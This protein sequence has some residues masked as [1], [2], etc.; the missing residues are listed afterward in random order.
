ML[1]ATSARELEYRDFRP[2]IKTG[3]HVCRAYAPVHVHLRL[4]CIKKTAHVLRF[5]GRVGHMDEK[6]DVYLAAMGMPCEDKIYTCTGGSSEN[7][8][9]MVQ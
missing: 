8:W 3:G 6:R 1:F 7:I 4:A 2:A 5:V 9:I